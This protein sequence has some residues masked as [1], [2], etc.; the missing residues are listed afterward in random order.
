MSMKKLIVF[1][2]L[3]GCIFFAYA[4]KAIVQP[5]DT[6]AAKEAST[7]SVNKGLTSNQVFEL[8]KMKLEQEKMENEMLMKDNPTDMVAILVPIAMFLFCFFIVFIVLYFQRKE[9]EA[10]YRVIEKAL[11]HGQTLPEGI[12]EEKKIKRQWSSVRTGIILLTLGIGIFLTFLLIDQKE[13][14]FLGIIPIFLGLGFL[15]IGWIENKKK[16]KLEKTE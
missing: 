16:N 6:S 13:A 9:R 1:L 12:F 8:E 3:A 14:S 11:E 4:A 5:A 15:L 7:D 10:K 2:V